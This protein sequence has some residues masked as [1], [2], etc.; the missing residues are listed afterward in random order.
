MIWVWRTFFST[1]FYSALIAVPLIAAT[2]SG[3]VELKDS[4][5]PAVRKKLDF[6]GVVIS[7][8]PVNGVLPARITSSHARMVQK[9]KTFTPHVLAIAVGTSVDLP[10]F[11]PIFHNAFSSYNGQI[12]DV[13]LYPPGTNRAV[14]F[15]REGVVRVFCNIHSS[16]SAVIVVL[17]TPF[18][19]TTDTSGAFE[20]PNVPVG[21]YELHVF[22]ERATDATLAQLQ[23]RVSVTESNIS[24]PAISISESGYL[25]IP[26]KNKYGRD[27]RPETDDHTIYPA[28]R[29]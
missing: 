7:L 25:P 5:D 23:R 1:G 19:D 16:M 11:D 17:A 4:R 22:H 18:F 20:I 10:N 24:L 27:Y 6:S 13:G 21:E 12:F 9:N 3:R 26:H 28:V 14:H 8:K 2:V 29:K 15:T